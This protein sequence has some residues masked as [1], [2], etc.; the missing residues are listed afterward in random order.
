[1]RYQHKINKLE[2]SRVKR[3]EQIG[4]QF[5]VKN[6]E[7]IPFSAT[8]DKNY[9]ALAE[10][11]DTHGHCE[12]PDDRAGLCLWISR[13]RSHF[14]KGKLPDHLKVK[15]QALEINLGGK[16][17]PFGLESEESWSAKLRAL[18][19]YRDT[20]HDCNVTKKYEKD[21]ELGTRTAVFSC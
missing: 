18:A 12:V 1:M 17:R 4:F 19:E 15:L 3:L 6:H 5:V 20:H 9:R 16:G 14:R 7:M 2:E 8:W 21:P 13:Q 11:R 10:F